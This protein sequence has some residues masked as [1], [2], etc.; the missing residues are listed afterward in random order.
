[1]NRYQTLKQLGDGTYGSV[2]LVRHKESGETFAV[3]TM[4]QKYYSWQE[5]M[6]LREIKSLK[7]LSHPNVVK[8]KEVIRENDHLFMV[9]EC[10][11]ANLYEVMKARRK[12]F[13]EV[14]VRNI[15]YQVMQGL[16]Y[17]HK[18]GF[19]HRDLK[20]EN[21]LC[22][23]TE[24]V[25]IADFGLAREIRSRPPYTDYVSTRWYRA[26]E[27]LLRSTKYNS[28]I[29]IWAIGT[30]MAELFTLRPLFP[31]SSE[32]DE[33]F[34]V[35]AVLGTP[36]QT[37][38]PEGLKLAKAMNFRFPQMS[39]TPL[40]NLIPMASANALDLMRDMMLWAPEKRPTCSQ[41]LRHE[42]FTTG[43]PLPVIQAAETK[44]K[45]KAKRPSKV[46][47]PPP[48]PASKEVSPA[49]PTVVAAASPAAAAAAPVSR[50][51]DLSPL[52]D[53]KAG[54]S[55]PAALARADAHFGSNT[56]LNSIRS[57]AG[58]R[59]LS[60][61]RDAR[62]GGGASKTHLD[63]WGRLHSGASSQQTEES[64]A[65]GHHRAGGR[66][67]SGKKKGAASGGE[68]SLSALLGLDGKDDLRQHQPQHASKVPKSKWS[69]EDGSSHRKSS[70]GAMPPIHPPNSGQRAA[71]Y[72]SQARYVPAD[73]SIAPAAA[74]GRRAPKASGS[75][76]AGAAVGAAGGRG[77]FM[78]SLDSL[79]SLTRRK[80][81]LASAAAPLAPIARAPALRANAV[82]RRTDW[83]SKYGSKF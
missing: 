77:N 32:M 26:P 49:K 59:L 28:P 34:K 67:A 10:M 15:I 50:K 17:M 39:A 22:N 25:K 80:P 57:G 71:K 7:K 75:H 68:T 1:M 14:T 79:S 6:D 55:R 69:F 42:F 65:I 11:E 20:P 72:A 4:K 40:R 66:A 18:H 41:A 43:P 13:P 82:N 24:L 64:S 33:I 27:V 63:G 44:D 54:K 61:E 9:F 56:S 45:E 36:S 74:Y 16:A 48:E 2:A 83:S 81:G 78:D 21:L 12:L 58:S 8:L 5:C 51:P 60:R 53:I 62:H 19:F 30:I 52:D 70:I 76:V 37:E 47:A 31:G 23:G 73:A 3:K 46:T 35:T 38:W 29:D